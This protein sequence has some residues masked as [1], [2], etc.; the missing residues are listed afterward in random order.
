MTLSLF[1]FTQLLCL[2]KEAEA[3]KLV[4][5]YDVLSKFGPVCE[6]FETVKQNVI[7]HKA[8]RTLQKNY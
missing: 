2:Q 4:Y 1:N 8:L 6:C 3:T 7:I 5:A